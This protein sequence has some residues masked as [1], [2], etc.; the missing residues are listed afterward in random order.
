MRIVLLSV[1]ICTEVHGNQNIES[2]TQPTQH[3]VSC[4][5][6]RL[7]FNKLKAYVRDRGC[8]RTRVLLAVGYTCTTAYGGTVP[9]FSRSRR[10][11][12]AIHG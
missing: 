5:G 8:I 4:L 11:S 12:S 6:L 1:A 3:T 7:S 2:I 10:S 9:Y